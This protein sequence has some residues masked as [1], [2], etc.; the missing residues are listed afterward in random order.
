M[1]VTVQNSITKTIAEEA[2]T[3]LENQIT[4]EKTKAA[5][6]SGQRTMQ[7]LNWTPETILAAQAFEKVF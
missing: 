5:L 6:R 4:D 2:S 7:Q 3:S 1:I